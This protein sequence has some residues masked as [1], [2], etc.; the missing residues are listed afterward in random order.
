MLAAT[1][2]PGPYVLVGHSLGALLIRRYADQY[3]EGIIG[4]VLVGPTHENT[5]LFNVAQK[6]WVRMRDVPAFGADSHSRGQSQ[7]GGERDRRSGDRC[8][9][10]DTAEVRQT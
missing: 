10:R 9:E 5:R 4:M 7:A 6:Q 3:P 8:N 2:V 1:K